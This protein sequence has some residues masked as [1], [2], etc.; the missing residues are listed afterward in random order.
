MD[1]PVPKNAVDVQ[2]LECRYDDSVILRDVT[3]FVREREI[4]FIAG[5]SGCGKTTLLRH[6]IGLQPP[7][8]GTIAYFGVD[9]ATL[10]TEGRRKLERSIGVLFQNNALWSDMTLAENVALPLVLH[11]A[12]SRE[13]RDE[14]VKLKLGQVG[15][16]GCQDSFPRELSGGMA[17]RAALAR[18][19]ALDPAILFFDEPTAGLD[20]IT[21]RQIDDLIQQV[22]QTVAATVIVV[23]HSLSSIFHV[24]DRLILLD[25]ESK[26][27]IAS[28]TPGELA[29]RSDDPRVKE[30]LDGGQ[31]PK[32]HSQP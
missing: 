5:R 3:F 4:F 28:G 24:A 2:Q 10:D 32:P 6:L 20:P 22:R 19:L 17:K 18:A 16:A 7:A 8:H 25:P 26:G 15:L 14:I 11:T 31:N 1:A 9:L 12:L 21:A 13:T 29:Q 23:S 27:I 30:F